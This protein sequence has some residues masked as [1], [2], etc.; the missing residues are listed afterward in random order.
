[1]IK[2]Y[3]YQTVLSNY[4]KYSDVNKDPKLREMMV[5]YYKKKIKK[6]LLSS[7][8]YKHKLL[9]KIS[10]SNLDEK[11]VD[12]IMNKYINTNRIY[13][14]LREFV[15]KRELNWYD[16]KKYKK[17]IKKKVLNFLIEKI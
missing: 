6:W 7:R 17:N 8:E 4:Y 3:K 9:K 13:K 10:N 1:M 2:K 12:E 15:N 14:I 5:T 16:L 11:I